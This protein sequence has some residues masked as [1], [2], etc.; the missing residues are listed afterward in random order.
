MRR[1]T[2]TMA[3]VASAMAT[4]PALADDPA[5][6]PAPASTSASA[7]PAPSTPQIAYESGVEVTI[8]STDPATEIFLAHGNPSIGEIP[9]PYERVG[10]TPMTIKLA[11]GTYSLETASPTQSTGHERFMVEQGRPLRIEIHPGDA[12]VKAVGA[13][14]AGLGIVS[15]VLGVVAVV[16]FSPNDSHYDRFGV[17][18]P[19]M[20]AGA[21]GCGI[22]IGMTVLGATAVDVQHAPQPARPAALLPT[23]TLTF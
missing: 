9:D 8:V 6:A 21:A 1:P 20:I 14:I 12:N 3:V 7:P 2:W 15:V 23:L 11:P 10:L 19:L 16:S 18:L 13:V 5:A 4:T 17:G 22:G